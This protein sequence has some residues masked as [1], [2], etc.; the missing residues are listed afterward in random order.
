MPMGG[1]GQ[2]FRDKG[3]NKPKPLIDVEGQPMFLRALESF[4]N[5]LPKHYIFVIRDDQDKEFHLASQIKKYL[6]EAIVVTISQN[7]RGATET[8]LLAENE[9]NDDWPLIVADCDMRFSSK[10][11]F[12]IANKSFKSDRPDG[13]LLTFHST[14]NRYSYVKTDE[15]GKV[16]ETAEKKVISDQAIAGAY[17]YSSGELFKSTARKLLNQ[18]ITNQMKEYY[19][20]LTYNFM[21]EDKKDIMTA[22]IDKFDSFGTPEELQEYLSHA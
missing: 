1:V 4:N 7:T 5:D 3:F 10:R 6:P 12:D 17:Y 21:I 13:L 8:C 14:N 9:I 2:R 22:L 20:S 16:I 18:P 19:L 11:Y 15:H